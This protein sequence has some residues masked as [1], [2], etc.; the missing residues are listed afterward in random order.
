MRTERTMV[1]MLS[2]CL[3][4]SA[5]MLASITSR[6]DKVM[7]RYNKLIKSQQEVISQQ[8][9]VIHELDMDGYMEYRVKKEI[10]DAEN[11]VQLQTGGSAIT[12]TSY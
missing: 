1:I 9:D 4:V 8:M 6:T 7:D 10:F 5:I 2:A 3:A 12:G 11:G